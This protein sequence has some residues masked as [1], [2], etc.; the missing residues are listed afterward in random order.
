MI[1]ESMRIDASSPM[2]LHAQVQRFLRDLLRKPE[3]RDGGLLP[4]EVTLSNRLGVSRGTV[5]TA[6]GQLVFEGLL[7]RKAGVGTRATP[8]KVESGIGAWRSFS[9]EMARKGIAVENFLQE[10]KCVPAPGPIAAALQIPLDAPAWRLDRVRGWDKLP[11]LHSRSWFHP[12]LGLNGK[13]DFS[14]PLYEVLKQE[15]G[16]VVDHAREEFKAVI[17]DAVMARHLAVR[18]NEPLLLRC[19]IVYDAGRRPVEFAEVHYV[20]TRFTLSIEMRREA[21]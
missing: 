3:Y 18:R 12:R 5:R 6:I 14:R 21:K 20:S 2:P 7:V 15:T 9:R 16:M 19:H 11:V 10:Y 8:Q 4:D 13:E 17:P 1:A